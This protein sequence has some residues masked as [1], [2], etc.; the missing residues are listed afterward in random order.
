MAEKQKETA[1]ISSV[2]ADEGQSLNQTT[3]TIITAKSQNIKQNNG[4]L[5]TIS[6]SELYD[7]SFEP[8]PVLV[9]NLLY[10]GTYLF[11]GA[12]KIG[13]SFFMAQLS[14]HVA[15]GLPLWNYV[16]HQGTVLYLALE[17][18]YGNQGRASARQPRRTV[19]VGCAWSGCVLLRI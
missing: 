18:D 19:S 14:Y 12:P 9:D 16:V 6:M 1:P 10:A 15:M 13:K 3:K 11:V 4:S 5:Q 8:K 7:T 2:G 17:D